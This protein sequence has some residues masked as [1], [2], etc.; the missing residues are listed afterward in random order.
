MQDGGSGINFDRDALTKII[1][2]NKIKIQDYYT[3][4]L[5]LFSQMLVCYMS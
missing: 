4:T 3:N 2:N 5:D 1:E